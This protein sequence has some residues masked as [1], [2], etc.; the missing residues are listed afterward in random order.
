MIENPCISCIMASV[1]TK[2][3]KARREW[4]KGR[5]EYDLSMA[6]L[7]DDNQRL[8]DFI[9]QRELEDGTILEG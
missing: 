7:R 5:L 6:T 9:Y 4:I 8:E 2:I 1:C 3:C